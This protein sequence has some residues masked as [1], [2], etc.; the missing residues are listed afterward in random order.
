MTITRDHFRPAVPLTLPLK[1]GHLSMVEPAP[2]EMPHQVRPVTYT[3]PEGPTF[4]GT[5]PTAPF[6]EDPTDPTTQPEPR[7]QTTGMVGRLHEPNGGGTPAG[8]PL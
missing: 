5:E 8:G 7:E 6:G 4:L 2:Q 1:R 3:T